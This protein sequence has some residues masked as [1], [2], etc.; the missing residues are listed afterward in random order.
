[1][2]TTA[3]L[4]ER[5]TTHGSFTSNAK[6]GQLLRQHFRES[7]GWVSMTL[8]QQEALDMIACK[9]SRILSGQASHADHWQDIAGYATL[10][11]DTKPESYD[12][13]QLTRP[14]GT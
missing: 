4:N 8:V 7:P 14:Y 13:R 11:I 5:Q 12:D 1:M 3:L 2:N 6:Y 9:L 10:V